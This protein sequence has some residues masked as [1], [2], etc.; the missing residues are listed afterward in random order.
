MNKACS[1]QKNVM[2]GRNYKQL[3]LHTRIF[4]GVVV[5][6]ATYLR[7]KYCLQHL[8]ILAKNGVPLLPWIESMKLLLQTYIEFTDLKPPS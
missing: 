7:I 2:Q 3:V 8:Q 6:N 5:L 1:K 4:K